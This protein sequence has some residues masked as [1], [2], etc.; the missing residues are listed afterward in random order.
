MRNR[1]LAGIFNEIA[2]L[3]EIKGDNPFRIRAYRRAA[4][5]I[6]TLSED[7]SNIPQEE[8]M[9]IPGIG[10][11]LAGKIGEYMQ[12]GKISSYEEL[13]KEVPGSLALLLSVP[14]LGPK[15]A[16]LLFD[17]LHITSLDDLEHFAKEHKLSRLPGIKEKTEENILKGIAMLRRGRERQPLGTVMPIADEIF[18]YLKRKA[19]VHKLSIA[20]SIRRWKDTV[21]DI[22]ILATSTD[23]KAVMKVFVKLPQVRDIIMQGTTK[24][25]VVTSEGI[26]VDLRVVEE[27]SFGA[28]L[29]YFTGSKSHNIRLREIAVRKGLKINEYGIFREKDGRRL[30]GDR[31]EDVYRLLGLSYIPP[32]LREDSG[33]IEASLEGRLPKLVTLSDIKGDL[34]VH[35]M[36]SDGSH[37]FDELIE[38]ARKKGYEYIAITDHSQGLGIAHGLSVE[39]LLEEKKEIDA[40][41]R[42]LKGFR[43]LAGTEVDIRGNGEIDFPD[44]VLRQ[45][46]IVVASIHSGFKQSSEKI[47]RRL[48]AAIQNPYVTVIA[49]PSGRLIGERDPYDVDMDAVFQAAKETGT[50]LEI[51]AYPL[52]LDLND[53]YAKKAKDMGVPI[54]ISTDTHIK[55]QFEFMRYGVSIARRGWL[56]KKDVFNTYRYKDL[57][58][59]IKKS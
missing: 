24:S 21:K 47:T 38:A 10:K 16:K 29:A 7:V 59:K 30:G 23:P 28:A 53:V 17:E 48:I 34:H 39:R 52:R 31:E 43:V 4:L 11:D 3:L 14:G 20:G 19:P 57:I 15:T 1:E 41:N 9:K 6:E 46:E 2:D 12:S 22:D 33:E 5:N 8:L 18:E 42:R 44:E 32:E 51:N 25:S 45:M 27:S 40:L 58:K 13:K 55:N 36:R 54:V 56:E 49:H 37:D 50:A 26:Q 35:T